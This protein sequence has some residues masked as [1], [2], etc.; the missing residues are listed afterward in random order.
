M[1]KRFVKLWCECGWHEMIICEY[2]KGLKEPPDAQKNQLLLHI[3]GRHATS[4]FRRK[5]VMVGM[6][7]EGSGVK[8]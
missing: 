6:T 7:V 4:L 1:S 3:Q 8:N 2:K 5:G